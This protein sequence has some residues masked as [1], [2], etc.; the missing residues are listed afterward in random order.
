MINSEVLE[1]RKQF[2]HEN[3]A[4][5]K[6]SGC[7]IDGEKTIVTKFTET[8]LCMPEE[9]TFKYFEIF[10]KTLSGTLGKNLIHMEFPLETEFNGG[11]QEFLL[12]LRIVS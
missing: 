12:K 4:I 9:E 6:F 5:T 7:Y 2:K 3:T 10:K 1:I 11:P 8:F